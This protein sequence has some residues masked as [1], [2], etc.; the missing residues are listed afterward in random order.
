M[1]IATKSE[2]CNL[3]VSMLGNYGTISDIDTPTNDKER[4][5]AQW[6]DLCRQF[7]LKHLMP[8]FALSR[9]TVGKL[10]ETPPFGYG[11]YYEYPQQ[12]IKLLGVGEIEDKMNNYS[13]EQTPNG[14]KAILHD[15]D[16]DEGMPVRIIIDVTDITKWTVEAVLLLAQ[17]VAAYTCRAITQNA[18]R[19]DKLLS[20][21][22][23]LLNS[24]SGLN[25]QENMP[26]R[27]SRSKFK[28][29]RY[30]NNPKFTDKR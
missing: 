28:G 5:C 12:A 25:A 16:Y 13:I 18:E 27:I 30:N 26:V 15:T 1:A 14:V 9:Q 29:A 21:L 3:A 23:A 2:V 4:V 22:P 8:N 19:A 10:S 11:Y 6:F 24:S 20:E 17:Y 7:V